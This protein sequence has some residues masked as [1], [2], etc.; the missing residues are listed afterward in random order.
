MQKNATIFIMLIV[1]LLISTITGCRSARHPSSTYI[2]PSFSGSDAGREPANAMRVSPSDNGRSTINPGR[3]TINL[4]V[5]QSNV[6]EL[7]EPPAHAV[8]A[9]APSAAI[10]PPATA[11]PNMQQNPRNEDDSPR[12][13][14]GFFDNLFNRSDVKDSPEP[15]T[16][17]IPARMPSAD[18]PMP[19]ANAKSEPESP[20]FFK[21]LFSRDDKKKVE[22]MS[23]PK[24]NLMST[25]PAVPA[26]ELIPIR[27]NDARPADQAN[28]QPTKESDGF[29]K[30]IFSRSKTSDVASSQPANEIPETVLLN[31]VNTLSIQQ[32]GSSDVLLRPG[33][34]LDVKVMV[35]GKNQLE[36]A[37]IRISDSGSI[38]LPMLGSVAVESLTMDVLREEL[39]TR[40]KRFYVNPEVLVDFVRDSSQ[41]GISPW[42]YVTVLGRVKNP[43]RIMIPATRDL[44]VSGAI[45]GAGGFDK[46]ARIEAIRVTRRGADGK[47]Q[48][49]R[50][51]NLNRVGSDGKAEDDFILGADDVVFVPEARF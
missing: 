35:A 49:Q 29:F 15:S 9:P 25:E 3:V 42:G 20:G 28:S 10:S 33:L 13:R 37:G 19:R 21:R 43:G 38:F 5:E 22:E 8:R 47:E 26:N 36:P 24:S 46:S 27:R 32:S 45:Q 2:N 17:V 11:A 50:T 34:L 39:T 44:T 6:R 31:D 18:T 14:R 40:Y 48:S 30:R 1:S 12:G 23:L 4:P 16:G 41:Q 51:V 7:N